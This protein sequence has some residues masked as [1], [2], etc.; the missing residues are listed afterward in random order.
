VKKK[1]QKNHIRKGRRIAQEQKDEK[2]SASI[3]RCA[4]K[5]N[6]ETTRKQEITA[7][8][9]FSD[10]EEREQEIQTWRDNMGRKAAERCVAKSYSGRKKKKGLD[11]ALN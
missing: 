2:K 7:M 1:T 11:A 6:E 10:L 8:V 5:K 3:F 9:G 4:T